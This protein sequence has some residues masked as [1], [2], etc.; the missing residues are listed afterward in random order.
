MPRILYQDD[1]LFVI[2]KPINLLSQIDA[3]GGDSVPKRLE[4]QGMTVK[5]VHRLDRATGGVMAYALKQLMNQS[6]QVIIMGHKFADL[7]C[8]GSAIGILRS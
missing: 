3:N 2:E 1:H 6:D 7:D 5:P 4:S 8:M